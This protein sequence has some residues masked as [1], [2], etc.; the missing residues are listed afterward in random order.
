MQTHIY[1]THL[2][3][4][5]IPAD[6]VELFADQ[7]LLPTLDVPAINAQQAEATAHALSGLPVARCERMDGDPPAPPF[8]L[9]VFQ[10]L[11]EHLQRKPAYI[12][13]LISQPHTR[14]GH[15][16]ADWQAVQQAMQLAETV[17]G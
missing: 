17:E 14:T 7:S 9:A 10:R 12:A 8:S 11:P 13:T 5:G 6:L 15:A 16:L 1:R 2:V 3:P 4:A